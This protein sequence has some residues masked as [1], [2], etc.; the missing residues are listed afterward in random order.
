MNRKIKNISGDI[1]NEVTKRVP[2]SM[3]I[4]EIYSVNKRLVTDERAE[5]NIYKHHRMIGVVKR[6]KSGKAQYEPGA[7]VKKRSNREA[8]L[9]ELL[10][11]STI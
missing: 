4:T 3:L 7:E 5:I 8:Y 6:G 1:A 10:G 9:S 11:K 2:T